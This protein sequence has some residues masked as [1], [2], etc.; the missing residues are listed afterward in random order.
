VLDSQWLDR[1]REKLR[2]NSEHY[3]KLLKHHLLSLI[4]IE[5][6][7]HQG[8]MKEKEKNSLL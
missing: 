4:A 3:T 1:M 6:S 2:L 8:A 5:T 7:V